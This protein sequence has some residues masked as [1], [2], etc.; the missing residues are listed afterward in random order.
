[1]DPIVEL[2]QWTKPGTHTGINMSQQKPYPYYVLLRRQPPSMQYGLGT[3]AKYQ[4]E[5]Q[6]FSNAIVDWLLSILPYSDRTKDFL[7]L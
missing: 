1:M 4:R 3:R 7:T 5:S 2:I 6:P